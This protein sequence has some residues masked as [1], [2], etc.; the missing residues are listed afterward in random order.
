MWYRIFGSASE[1]PSP[2]AI[3][4][5]LA[6]PDASVSGQF[7]TDASG[8]YRAD[9][10]VDGVALQLERYL[11][12]EEGIR[13]ELNSWAAWLETRETISPAAPLMERM[14]QTRQLFT[15]QSS[16]KS[17]RAELLCRFLANITVGVYQIDEHGFFAADGTLLV[18]EEG[19]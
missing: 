1:M 11:A 9:L 6:A 8:W 13:A 10:L 16:E 3:L 15:L 19:P 5:C 18:P 14:I 17:P 12:E 2:A 7:A 4:D